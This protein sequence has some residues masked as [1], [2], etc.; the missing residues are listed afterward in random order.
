MKKYTG[1][2]AGWV[3]GWVIAATLFSYLVSL[4]LPAATAVQACAAWL[5]PI[6]LWSALGKGI[7]RQTLLLAGSGLSA[8]V[9]SAFHGVDLPLQNMLFMNL[10][11]LAM[12]VAVTFLSLTNSETEC[13][14]LPEGKKAVVQ[15]AVS[16]H[17]LASVINLSVLIVFGDRLRKKGRLSKNQLIILARCFCAAAW[18]SPFFIATGVALTYAPG[19][20]WYRTMIP[21]A[22]MSG[23]ALT[24][25][26][27]EVCWFSRQGFS[28]Y[29]FRIN[30]MAIPAV[31]AFLVILAHYLAPDVSMLT[32]I[33]ILAPA[34]A[35]ILMKQRPRPETL[36]TF[37]NTKLSTMGSQ[38]ALFLS[39]GIFST[40]I[41][42]VIQVY[43]DLFTLG[44][45]SFTPWMF[46]ILLGAMI[47]M[48]ILGV[49]PIVSIS[50]VSP[51]LLPLSP[52]P[53]RM[54]FLFLSS[55]AISTACSPLSGIGLA[56][57]SRYHAGAGEIIRSNWHY[58]VTMWIIT[59]LLNLVWFA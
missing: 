15:T 5:V 55:W 9:F 23:F 32:L 45:A 40:G 49:H 44:S 35:V 52:D 22:I 30:S 31:L 26:I 56:L 57:V 18:W 2:V 29:P 10:P 7:R 48:G 20:S 47:L 21:G 6:L 41:K 59:S 13:E 42:A 38:F 24:Y 46:S 51:L 12:L 36:R 4:L 43:P 27:V 16:T 1:W 37:I 28:G 54:G 58:A 53:S 3:T 39:A 50:I 25:A 17:V 8:L 34:G 14:T 19:M 33:C 11:L